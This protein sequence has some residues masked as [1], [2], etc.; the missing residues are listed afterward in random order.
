MIETKYE[1]KQ[2]KFS[3]N[4]K[5]LSGGWKDLQNFKMV[6]QNFNFIGYPVTETTMLVDFLNLFLI[7]LGKSSGPFLKILCSKNLCVGS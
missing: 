7:N 5:C 1:R 4:F 2:M 6:E 3:T